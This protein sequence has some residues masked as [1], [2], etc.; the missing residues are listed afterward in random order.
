MDEGVGEELAGLL[1][2]VAMLNGM[3]QDARQ[4][5]HVLALSFHVARF[6]QR[7]VG[8]YEGDDSLLG[9]SLPLA[10]HSYKTTQYS[11]QTK[12]ECRHRM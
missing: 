10:D 6:E 5:T 9:L 11:N 4:Q 3:G 7:E 2:V 8:E 1:Q 12:K